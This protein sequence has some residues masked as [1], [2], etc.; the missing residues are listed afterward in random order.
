MTPFVRVNL[1]NGGSLVIEQTEA[2][3]SIYVNAG[4]SAFGEGT[5]AEKAALGVNLWAAKQVL[6]CT[7]FVEAYFGCILIVF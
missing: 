2:L 1:L 6:I 7:F 5:F 3:V 4:S